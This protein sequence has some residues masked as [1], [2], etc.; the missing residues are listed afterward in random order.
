[1]KAYQIRLEFKESKP[2]IWRRVIMPGNSTFERLHYTIQ[3]SFYFDDCHLYMFNL[4]DHNLEVT[5]DDEAY[6]IHQEYKENQEE[7]EKTLLALGTPFAKRQLEALRTVVYKPHEIKMDEYLRS[8]GVL[9]YVYDFGDNWEISITLEALVEDYDLAFPRLLAGAEGAPLEN[10]GGLPGWEE[11]LEAYIDPRHPDHK[12][13]QEWGKQEGFR[14]Y[15]EQHIQN[16]LKRGAKK[17]G[18]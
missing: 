12:T 17:C 11:F 10:M 7:M 9:H 18:F 8:D 2:R 6:Q 16:R 5:N 14:E 13:A 4:P 1:M 15:D 3:N